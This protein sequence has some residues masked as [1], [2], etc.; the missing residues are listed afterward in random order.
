MISAAERPL[1]AALLTRAWTV[2]GSRSGSQVRGAFAKNVAAAEDP[3]AAA[4]LTHGWAVGG[5]HSGDA[6]RSAYQKNLAATGDAFAAAQ[7][8]EGWT[9]R[10]AITGDDVRGAYAKNLAAAGDA[11]AAAILTN[12]W[13][14]RGGVDGDYMRGGYAKNLA[15]T[16]DAETAAILTNGWTVQRSRSGDE[17]RSAYVKNFAATD[18]ARAAATL[19]RAW[20]I[21]NTSGD[22]IRGAYAKNLAAT[23]DALAAAQL[24]SGWATTGTRDGAAVRDAF[25]NNLNKLGRLDPATMALAA[26]A[27]DRLRTSEGTAD[28]VALVLRIYELPEIAELIPK[29][30]W[31][32]AVSLFD[33]AVQR[34]NHVPLVEGVL[35][36]AKSHLDE[37]P[38]N[39]MTDQLRR[40]TL[41]LIERN[42][43]R[44]RGDHSNDPVRGYANHAD[45]A[46]VGRVVENL[47]LLDKMAMP[48]A[49][50]STAEGA[51][52]PAATA[53]P[54]GN[55]TW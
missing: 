40:D 5:H 13:A 34:G 16:G 37:V 33:D 42:Q 36:R 55:L 3:V 27:R 19:T 28:D 9:L 45:Y 7:L 46:E 48:A 30:G 17:M 11:R 44:M 39:Q 54:A 20:A 23:H 52:A 18:D 35:A 2:S 6:I 50:S 32:G 49:R 12:G 41:E 31:H 24:T 10:G 53:A 25:A 38:A 47:K 51:V 8:T 26:A 15:A 14:R 1:V 4:V 29:L 22:S 21:A 43:A